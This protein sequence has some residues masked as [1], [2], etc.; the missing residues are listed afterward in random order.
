MKR[1]KKEHKKSK[2]EQKVSKLHTHKI[3]HV[4]F[5]FYLYNKGK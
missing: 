4:R 3:L 5:T 1:A 2:K